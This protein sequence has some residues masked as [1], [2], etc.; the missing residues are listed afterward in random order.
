MP[1]ILIQS[2]PILFCI[3]IDL[4]CRRV[5]AHGDRS[6]LIAGALSCS[7]LNTP[8]FQIPIVLSR[9]YLREFSVSPIMS[10]LWYFL[11]ASGNR[12]NFTMTI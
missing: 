10:V 9:A 2:Q 3:I 6:K 11:L 4:L 5:M 7:S 1:L 12:L 8:L